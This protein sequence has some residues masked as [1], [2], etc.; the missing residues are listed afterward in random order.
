MSR[1]VN[2]VTLIGNLGQDPEL[3][4]VGDNQVVNVSLA[5]S[6]QWKDKSGERQERTE[7]VRL[8][9][10]GPPAGIV[11]QYCHKGSRIYVE[12]KVHCRRGSSEKC[13]WWS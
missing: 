6:E 5:V 11:A 7:W 3:K 12:G 2:K 10:W 13:R 4:T 1:G 9:I 8:A